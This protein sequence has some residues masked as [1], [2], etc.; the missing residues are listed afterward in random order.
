MKNSKQLKFGIAENARFIT[1]FTLLF[2]MLIMPEMLQAATYKNVESRPWL[3]VDQDIQHLSI[4]PNSKY[5][6]FEYAREPGLYIMEIENRNIY[7]VSKFD[8]NGSFFWSP[9]GFRI[10]LREHKLRGGAIYSTISGY[11]GFIHKKVD[12]K[13][14]KGKSSYLNFDPRDLRFTLAHENGLFQSKIDFPSRRLKKWQSYK[15]I[16][17]GKWVATKS[18]VFWHEAKLNKMNKIKGDMAQVDSFSISSDGLNI[19]WATSEGRLYVSHRGEAARLI[20]RGKHP[21]WHPRLNKLAFSAA[22]MIG[23]VVRTHDIKIMDAKGKV[24]KLTNTSSFNEVWPTWHPNGNQL[25]FARENHTDIY[26]IDYF[27]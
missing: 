20:G 6:A 14:F 18:G 4:S 3:R 22:V 26:L 11:D 13:T 5:I 2:T 17:T 1:L 10:F 16:D 8:V 15:S 27:E 9:D 19:A 7:Q 12:L 25:S 23:T 24:Q 21:S